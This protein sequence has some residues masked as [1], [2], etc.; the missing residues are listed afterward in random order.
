MLWPIPAFSG[1]LAALGKVFAINSAPAFHRALNRENSRLAGKKLYWAAME[2]PE[3]PSKATYSA[4]DRALIRDQLLAYSEQ[5]RIGTPTLQ[6]RI[7]EASG[8]H[9]YELSNKTLQRFLAGATRTN[10]AFVWLCHKFLH[11]V[12]AVDPVKSYGDAAMAFFQHVADPEFAAV[13]GAYSID[14]RDKGETIGQSRLTLAAVS[15][16]PYLRAEESSDDG[17]GYEGIAFKRTKGLS[18]ILRDRLTRLQRWH[19]YFPGPGDDPAI[20]TG[21]TMTPRFFGHAEGGNAVAHARMRRDSESA[22]S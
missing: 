20:L 9:A 12:D 19:V 18:L 10:D 13:A 5:H 17:G 8:R 15:D 4:D 21:Q 14:E 22:L 2:L 6:T 16:R 11:S 3:T 7:A 1:R